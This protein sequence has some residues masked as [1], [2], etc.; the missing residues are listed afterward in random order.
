[1]HCCFV[2]SLPLI[3]LPFPIRLVSFPADS[4]S[5]DSSYSPCCLSLGQR[6]TAAKL[7]FSCLSNGKLETFFVSVINSTFLALCLSIS[8]GLLLL[9]LLHCRN[10]LRIYSVSVICFVLSHLLF[11]L[12]SLVSALQPACFLLLTLRHMF[13][14]LFLLASRHHAHFLRLSSLPLS[15]YG[16]IPPY[17]VPFLAYLLSFILPSFLPLF[18]RMPPSLSS[19]HSFLFLPLFP[20]PT[21]YLFV[22]YS[23]PPF[24][25]CPR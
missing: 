18:L 23:P 3:L 14:P 13:L 19:F 2:P 1:M 12:F 22:L 9:T 11:Q 24:L 21:L 17:F 6:G 7:P 10:E 25:P 5:S 20:S 16:P 4:I 15:S 8:L